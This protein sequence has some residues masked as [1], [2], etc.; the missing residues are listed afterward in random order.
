VEDFDLAA[1]VTN[2][3]GTKTIRFR[4]R[5]TELNPV[6]YDGVTYLI[7]RAVSEGAGE[8][9]YSAVIEPLPGRKFSVVCLAKGALT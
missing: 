7:M 2:A 4:G 3:E 1:G 6:R 5:Y 9:N 8:L